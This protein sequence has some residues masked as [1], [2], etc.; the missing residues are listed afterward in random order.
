MFIEF[1]KFQQ[2][3]KWIENRK[4]YVFQKKKIAFDF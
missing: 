2:I 3:V 4:M 1:Q